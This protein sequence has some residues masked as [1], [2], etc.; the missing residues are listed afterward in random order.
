MRGLISTV[1]IRQKTI[2]SSEQKSKQTN[3]DRKKNDDHAL[4]GKREKNQIKDSSLVGSFNEA[5]I[6]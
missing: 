2:S 1:E 5:S 6:S 3:E 4:Q